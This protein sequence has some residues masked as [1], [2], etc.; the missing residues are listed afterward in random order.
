MSSLEADQILNELIYLPGHRNE[1][2][3]QSPLPHTYIQPSDLPK[4]FRWDD[5]NGQ[6]YLTRSL[7]QHLPQWCGSCWAHGALSALADRIKIAR[8]YHPRNEFD[9]DYDDHSETYDDINLSIQFVLNC[10]GK[11]AGSCLGGSH[12]GVYD[13]VHQYGLIPYDTCQPYLAC[14]SNSGYGFC[15]AT[16]TTCSAPNICRTCSFSLFSKN[17]CQSIDSFPNA[18]VAEF[19]TITVWDDQNARF[20]SQGNDIIFPIQAEIWA[21]GPVA[22]TVNGKLLHTYQGGVYDNTTASKETTHVV[23]LVGW[24]LCEDDGATYWIA[25]NSW[26]SYWGE[27]GYFRILA[28]QNVLGIEEKIA[29]ATPGHFSIGNKA[30]VYKDPSNKVVLADKVEI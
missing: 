13:F 30:H 9:S 7:N 14:S 29:W 28:G 24:G 22:A 4:S 20:G 19:G 18:S 26:G 2:T 3:I 5:V 17:S 11:I 15:S 6:S 8:L 10:G 27:M 1:K 12:S 23:S 25:R 16:N 21:R